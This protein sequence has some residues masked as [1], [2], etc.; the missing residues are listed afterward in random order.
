MFYSLTTKGAD[1]VGLS[2]MK[3]YMKLDACSDDNLIEGMIGAATEWGEKYTG[4]EFTVN[5]WKLEIDCFEARIEVRRSPVDTIDKVSHLVNALP[6]TV[7]SSVYYL[8]K[9]TFISEILLNDGQDWPT[10][11][12]EREQAIIIDFTTE[13]FRCGDS[14]N[15]AIMRH[16]SFWYKNRGDCSG[17]DEAASESDVKSLYNLF[18]IP[19][20]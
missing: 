20:T 3:T 4:R 2:D 18:K 11:T 12:D 6:V 17:C 5:I 8:K 7:P 9:G 16:V 13:Q 19:R 14:I 15:N 1:P 10:D